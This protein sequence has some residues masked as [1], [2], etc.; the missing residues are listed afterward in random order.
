MRS[1]F[2]L[3]GV[4]LVVWLGLWAAAEDE[5]RDDAPAGRRGQRARRFWSLFDYRI[6]AKVPA[7]ETGTVPQGTGWRQR[8]ARK[9]RR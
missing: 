9:Q 3:L 8:A 6:A 2:Y 5:E 1:L 4:L 7:R